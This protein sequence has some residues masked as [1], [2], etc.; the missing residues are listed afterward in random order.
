MS[1]LA[2][3]DDVV[4]EIFQRVGDI[5]SLLVVIPSVSF[6]GQPGPDD[7]FATAAGMARSSVPAAA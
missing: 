4:V 2:L 6:P 5:A 1:I 3:P 7:S